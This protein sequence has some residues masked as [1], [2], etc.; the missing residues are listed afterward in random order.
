M[1]GVAQLEGAQRAA[2][3]QFEAVRFEAAPRFEAA[4]SFEAEPL[5]PVAALIM[6]EDIVIRT[7]N[8][9]VVA[10]MLAGSLVA[11]LPFIVA[12][13]TQEAVLLPAVALSEAEAHT[14]PTAVVDAGANIWLRPGY[15]GSGANA[16]A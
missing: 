6:A 11:A 15:F 9:A 5:Q 12:A 3:P 1:P 13:R 14:S 4:R 2:V 10:L 7:T 16:L 8:I